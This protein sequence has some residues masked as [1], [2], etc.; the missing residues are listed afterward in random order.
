MENNFAHCMMSKS[1]MEMQRV[2]LEIPKAKGTKPSLVFE[3]VKE[4]QAVSIVSP[5]AA[6]GCGWLGGGFGFTCTLTVC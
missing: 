1:R 6:S 3:S 4:L 5:V 2:P